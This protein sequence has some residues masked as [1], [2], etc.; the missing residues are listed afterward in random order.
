MPKE[1]HDA[2]A[3]TSDEML[4]GLFAVRKPSGRITMDLLNALK[5]LMTASPLFYRATVTDDAAR[6]TK[7]RRRGPYSKQDK[8]K[9]GQAGTLDPLASGVLGKFILHHLYSLI[10]DCIY[11]VQLSE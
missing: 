9:L 2:A 11:F 6:H 5:P 8:I 1:A 3:K 10:D 7:R 4:S